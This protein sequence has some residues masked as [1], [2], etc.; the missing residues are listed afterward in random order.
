MRPSPTRHLRPSHMPH[1]Q[2][3]ARTPEPPEAPIRSI[4]ASSPTF[5]LQSASTAP[6]IGLQLNP[7][8]SATLDLLSHRLFASLEHS[9][10]F[11]V[12]WRS[13]TCRSFTSSCPK[14]PAKGRRSSFPRRC[15]PLQALRRRRRFS[16]VLG[17]LDRFAISP[18]V[19]R[20]KPRPNSCSSSPTRSVTA[21]AAVCLCPSLLAA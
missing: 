11:V 7:S 12:R 13:R 8:S 15:Q 19:S 10:I 17:A 3:R 2:P 5:L 20:A 14:L 6:P 4:A 21:C 18:A 16:V 9:W 1:P